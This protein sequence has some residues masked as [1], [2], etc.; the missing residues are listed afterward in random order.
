L[1]TLNTSEKFLTR[2]FATENIP[3]LGRRECAPR[4]SSSAKPIWSL[5]GRSSLQLCAHTK[6]STQNR[7]SPR[8]G[9]LQNL[10]HKHNMVSPTIHKTQTTNPQR[11]HRE[12]L[13]LCSYLGH[14]WI[15]VVSYSEP[16]LEERRADTHTTKRLLAVRER[17]EE[18]KN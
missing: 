10:Q 17:G 14:I 4:K 3:R 13:I 12:P 9:R 8:L 15:L 5:L 2:V 7:T 1:F 18:G 6:H 16:G 11:K